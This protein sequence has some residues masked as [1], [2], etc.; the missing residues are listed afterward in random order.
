M[1]AYSERPSIVNVG[2]GEDVHDRASSRALVADVV[3]FDGEHRLR[4]QQ[5]R[6]HAAQAARRRARLAALG[7]QPRIALKDGLADAYKAFLAGGAGSSAR[8]IGVT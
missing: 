6:R 2:C 7:W 5:A 1:Q 8:S 3:G 4:S